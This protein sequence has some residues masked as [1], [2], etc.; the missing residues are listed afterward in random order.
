MAKAQPVSNA[1]NHPTNHATNQARDAH[2]A[3]LTKQE[4]ERLAEFRYE[5]RRY[6][7]QTELEA[8]KLDLTPQ[9]YQLMLA[10]KGFP[11]RDWANI[12]E[13]AE[14]LQI[15][16]NAVIGLVN[17]AEARGLLERRP[18]SNG[19]DRRI[20]EIHLTEQGE[21]ALLQL[22]SALHDERARMRSAM[23]ALQ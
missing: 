18:D 10:V 13:L 12:T 8:R 14:R 4:Y 2:T 20:V 22:A 6:L 21:Q 11:G 15:R 7:R 17:R 16:H 19:G 1:A 9:H 3:A 5:L 23:A